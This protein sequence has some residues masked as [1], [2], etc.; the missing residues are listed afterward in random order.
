MAIFFLKIYGMSATAASFAV[1]QDRMYFLFLSMAAVT[2]HQE[3]I[4]TDTTVKAWDVVINEIMADPDPA[5]GS[6]HYPEYVELYNKKAA[7]IQLKGW[8]FCTGNTCKS[9]PDIII[10]ADSFLVLTTPASLSLFPAEVNAVGIPAFPAL[11]NTGQTLQ[12]QN[13]KGNII[14]VTAYTDAWYQDLNKKD[15]GYSLEQI[16]P[17][18]PCA[19]IMNW[20]ASTNNSGGSPG[21]RNSI[22]AS[23]PDVRSPEIFRVNVI[24]PD[25]LEI[26]FTEPL[27]STTLLNNLS[28]A[29]ST[30]GNPIKISLSGPSF[31]SVV[32][33][34][35]TSI[36]ESVVYTITVGTQLQDCAGNAM[37][38]NST[39]RF[40]LPVK[41][42]PKDIAINELLFD[43][44][45]GGVDFVEL[46]NCSQKVLDLKSM[47]LCHY[48]T[49]NHIFSGMEKITA[50]GYLFFPGEYLVLSENSE[51]VK[52]QYFT[53][54]T[55]AFLT[56]ENLPALNADAGTICMKT[57]TD[58]IDNVTYQESM[59]FGLLKNT[60]GI[61]LERVNYR[62]PASDVT[63]WHSAASSVAGATPGYKNSQYMDEGS[64]ADPVSVEP[65]IFSPDEDGFQDVV[66]L[67]YHFN[68]PMHL[69][70]LIYDSSGRLAKILVNN[71]LTG[72][73]GAYSWDG[74]NNEKE[75]ERI[76]IYIFY[77][78]AVNLSGSVKR[79]KKICVLAGKN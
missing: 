43:P 79:Y 26:D 25:R 38:K 13:N 12:L 21:K 10:P 30:I 78:E 53:N 58:I 3:V 73:D 64:T 51:V 63:N 15:G 7:P 1:N 66:T 57:A 35:G 17:A 52:A 6:M 50:S 60:K 59:H 67:Q 76:G 20:R 72:P 39:A 74:I 45:E 8:K 9:L 23:N 22:R 40:A 55:A 24:A 46:V 61:S 31:K 19:E 37:E 48:D 65:E 27:D 36:K 71:E 2:S 11:S 14:S 16:D 77:V 28:Y 41:V 68:E 18:N 33:T 75:K 32:L 29:I 54:N 69:N 62:R 5:A 56:V 44:K 49:I 4:P 34:L 47:I 70:V 42:L